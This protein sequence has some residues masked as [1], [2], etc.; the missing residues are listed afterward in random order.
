MRKSGFKVQEN[1]AL[2]TLLQSTG[3]IIM[4][5]FNVELMKLIKELRVHQIISMHDELQ[6]M[7]HKEDKEQLLIAIDQA[8]ET[9]YCTICKKYRKKDM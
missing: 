8:I 6:F 1:K 2:N 5:K 4:K 7:C 3:S 9:T